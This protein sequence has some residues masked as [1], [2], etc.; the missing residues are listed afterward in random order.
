MLLAIWDIVWPV[1]GV[2]GIVVEQREGTL[3]DGGSSVPTMP[4]AGA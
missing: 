2:D 1:A 4:V 3:L